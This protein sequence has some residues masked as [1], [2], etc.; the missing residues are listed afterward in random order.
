MVARQEYAG[1]SWGGLNLP[2]FPI[3]CQKIDV[4]NNAHFRYLDS[5]RFRLIDTSKCEA[6]ADTQFSIFDSFA[7]EKQLPNLSRCGN[8]VRR[9]LWGGGWVTGRST[10]ILYATASIGLTLQHNLFNAA[11]FRWSFPTLA[12][13]PIL[14]DEYHE[15]NSRCT[16]KSVRGVVQVANEN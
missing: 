14:D 6:K 1:K 3:S 10:L 4:D 16:P 11:R 8:T 12:Y 9:D 2:K 13:Y 15:V 7:L 5:C